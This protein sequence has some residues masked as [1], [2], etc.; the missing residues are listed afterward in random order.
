MFAREGA[1]DSIVLDLRGDKLDAG[2]V[3]A[4]RNSRVPP[5]PASHA[6]ERG[7]IDR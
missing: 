7:F 2:A 1:K 5:S 3:V 4:L 6:D